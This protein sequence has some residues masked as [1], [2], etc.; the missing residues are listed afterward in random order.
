MVLLTVL[1]TTFFMLLMLFFRLIAQIYVVINVVSEDCRISKPSLVVIAQ[2]EIKIL[3]FLSVEI[4]VTN[5][6]SSHGEV[7]SIHEEFHRRRCSC[8]KSHVQ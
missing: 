3:G 8:D 6:I 2:V 4:R 5:L 7:L 1:F